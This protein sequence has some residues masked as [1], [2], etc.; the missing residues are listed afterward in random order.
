MREFESLKSHKVY[1]ILFKF[2]Y[3]RITNQV[4]LGAIID[5]LVADGRVPPSYRANVNIRVGV[6]ELLGRIA[7]LQMKDIILSDFIIKSEPDY[8]SFLVRLSPHI[9]VGLS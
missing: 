8:F 1:D 4:L 3:E 2:L 7:P 5:G 9:K 6:F